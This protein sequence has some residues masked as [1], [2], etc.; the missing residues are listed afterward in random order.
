M[1]HINLQF[2]FKIHNLK[3]LETYILELL[4][5]LVFLASKSCFSNLL[6]WFNEAH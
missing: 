6:A 2:L 4:K 3:H 5:L 1:G